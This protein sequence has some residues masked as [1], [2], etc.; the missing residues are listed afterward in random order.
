MANKAIFL[1]KLLL[2]EVVDLAGAITDPTVPHDTFTQISS[3]YTE[4]GTPDHDTAWSVLGRL[5]SAGDIDLTAL[6]DSLGNALDLTG[7]KIQAIMIK[8]DSDNL[9]P[10]SFA[11]HATN[12]Y[13]IFGLA[14]FVDISPGGAILLLQNG[15]NEGVSGTAKI[16]E[17]TGTGNETF[18]MALS[19]GD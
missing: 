8:C 4:G 19:I 6:T 1:M 3:S 18:D 9:S 16:I 10:I 13:G 2:N 7:K 14:S 5:V 12:G 11:E 15:G 17:I